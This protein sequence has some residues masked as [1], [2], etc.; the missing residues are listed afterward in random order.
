M[1]LPLE[2]VKIKMNWNGTSVRLFT[3]VL[4]KN[5]RIHAPETK[6][7][8]EIP[9]RWTHPVK[10]YSKRLF[11]DTAL[12]KIRTWKAIKVVSALTRRHLERATQFPAAASAWSGAWAG[13]VPLLGREQ[14]YKGVKMNSVR[15]DNKKPYLITKIVSLT[16]DK[17]RESP[18]DPTTNKNHRQD[19][20][21]IAFHHVCQHA[22]I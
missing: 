19:I 7:I 1:A 10:A 9:R 5:E 4:S 2:L 22:G 13:T 18:V 15:T 21:H 16:C 11:K 17:P 6:D 12:N 20:C 8:Q 14:N 3:I